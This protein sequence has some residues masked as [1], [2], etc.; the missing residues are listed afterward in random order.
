[1]SRLYFISLVLS[2]LYLAGCQGGDDNRIQPYEQ[3]PAYWQ[4]RS[5]PL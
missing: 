4:Y 5:R 3:N 1:M 2:V